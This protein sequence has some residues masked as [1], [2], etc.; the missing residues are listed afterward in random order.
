MDEENKG[1]CETADH[2]KRYS[3]LI[4]YRRRG[5]GNWGRSL[6]RC[7]D[8][9]ELLA[10]IKDAETQT[11]LV[12]FGREE[13]AENVWIG[14]MEGPDWKWRHGD[15]YI[16]RFFWQ[17]PFP[18]GGR[19]DCIELSYQDQSFFWS[20]RSHDHDVAFICQYDQ[21][22]QN[23]T[24]SKMVLEYMGNCFQFIDDPTTCGDAEI[25]CKG[26]GGFLAEIYDE[27]TNAL[28]AERAMYL[29]DNN[30]ADGPWWIGGYD[31]DTDQRSWYWSDQTKMIFDAWYSGQPTN[32]NHECVEMHDDYQ[33]QWDD[34]GCGRNKHAFCQIGLISDVRDFGDEHD[35]H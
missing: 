11:F 10:T 16:E 24:L 23:M 33:Y 12:K 15:R 19:D 1:N 4:C 25:K 14:A 34:K 22:C 5:N 2:M 21:P 18:N 27:S 13:I 3:D 6:K 29:K 32:D 28:L 35:S 9:N 7:V 17:S 20:P 30:L 26:T 31:E 8:N